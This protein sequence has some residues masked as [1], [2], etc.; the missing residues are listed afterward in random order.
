MGHIIFSL[1]GWPFYG[2]PLWVFTKIPYATAHSVYGS[3]NWDHFINQLYFNVG[4]PVYI[5][6]ILG[7]LFELANWIKQGRKINLQEL[8]LVYGVSVAFVTAHSLFWAM[9]IFNSMGLNRVLVSIFPLCGVIA[10]QGFERTERILPEAGKKIWHVLFLI[11]AIVFPFMDNPASTAFRVGFEQN[12]EHHFMSKQ[13]A[14]YLAKK[15]PDNRYFTGEPE[16]GLFTDRDFIGEDFWIYPG[17][18][19][20][21]DQMK[22]GDILLLDSNRFVNNNGIPLQNIKDRGNLQLDTV[23]SFT[24]NH[25]QPNQFYI[26]IYP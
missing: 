17:R 1:A 13:L 4:P 23:F 14:P 7:L 9:G 12:P 25:R 15:F 3:G 11:L 6:M 10:I 5:A 2:D 20:I 21:I 19:D 18:P 8:Y 22:S 16:L 26:F 24:D